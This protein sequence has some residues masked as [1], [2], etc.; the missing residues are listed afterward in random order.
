MLSI[1]LF[2]SQPCSASPPTSVAEAFLGREVMKGRELKTKVAPQTLM[3]TAFLLQKVLCKRP[4]VS[5]I[6]D[7]Y[8]GHLRVEAK[9]RE[10]H[11]RGTRS[12][13]MSRSLHSFR[14]DTKGI[15]T[16]RVTSVSYHRRY[17]WRKQAQPRLKWEKDALR[18]FSLKN[19][20]PLI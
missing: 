4:S 20:F 3:S 17:R 1:G 12:K 16:A 5:Q 6:I 19:K 15:Q 9:E 8:W 13:E 11:L 10:S 2:I 14:P 7:S 18:N